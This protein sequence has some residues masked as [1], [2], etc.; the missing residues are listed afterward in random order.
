MDRFLA[1]KWKTQTEYAGKIINCVYMDERATVKF[2]GETD[3]IFSFPTDSIRSD[4]DFM[5]L[6]EKLSMFHK[7]IIF[8]DADI[9]MKTPVW[10][11]LKSGHPL[12]NIHSIWI[13]NEFNTPVDKFHLEIRGEEPVPHLE[14]NMDLF[15]T[16]DDTMRVLLTTRPGPLTYGQYL[17]AISEPGNS[18]GIIQ[19]NSIDLK[20][21][22][23]IA[24]IS[25]L[26]SECDASTSTNQEISSIT[27]ILMTS[28]IIGGRLKCPLRKATAWSKNFNANFRKKRLNMINAPQEYLDFFGK[29]PD[30]IVDYCFNSASL[31]TL[32]SAPFAPRHDKKEVKRICALIKNGK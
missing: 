27:G 16:H 23:D 11:F 3:D 24:R 15:D 10:K 4:S 7:N 32:L 19:E 17:N 2:I 8:E 1:R 9:L 21:L 20:S 12:M 26:I 6:F 14:R 22:Q 31:E 29:N 5:E 13:P 18:L 28:H 25:E 30:R